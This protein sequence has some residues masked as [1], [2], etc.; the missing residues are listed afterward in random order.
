MRR[1]SARIGASRSTRR[2][3]IS[4]CSHG[5]ASPRASRASAARAATGSTPRALLLSLDAMARQYIEPMLAMRWPSTKAEAL[6]ARIAAG[7]PSLCAVCRS[8]GRGRVCA[9]CRARFG[10]AMPRCHRCALPV[11]A[12]IAVC[13]ACLATP[14]PYDAAVAAVDYRPPW[15]RLVTAFTFHG[16]IDL[17]P[18]FADAIVAAA[19]RRAA[20]RPSLLMPVPLAPGRWREWHGHQE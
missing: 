7:G 18:V 6:G 17:A 13:G 20:P 11:N 1:G 2:R 8:W 12:T 16:A 9:S 19:Q 4:P 3:A 5:N 14:P 10:A 15:D